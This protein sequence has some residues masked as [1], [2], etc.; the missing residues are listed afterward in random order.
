VATAL[1]RISGIGSDTATET[2]TAL[3]RISV[4][5]SDTATETATALPRISRINGRIQQ[6]Q[7]LLGEL[8]P[9]RHAV[10]AVPPSVFGVVVS[11]RQSVKSVAK[12]WLL[13]LQYPIQ[14]VKAIVKD[15]A[16]AGRA[17]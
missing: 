13:P 6:R 11:G 9:Q 17:F 14:S 3:P 16:P 8:Q 5:G 12:Q 7:R 2:A 10:V 15:L 4:I 1:P